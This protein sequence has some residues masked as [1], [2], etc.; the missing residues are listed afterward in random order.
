VRHI[1]KVITENISGLAKGDVKLTA[2]AIDHIEK[3]HRDQIRNAGFESITDF[4]R[5]SLNSIDAVYDAGG[6]KT[7]CLVSRSDKRWKTV[8]TELK[9]AD[10]GKIY[11]VKTAYPARDA[12][13]K[14]KKL[15]WERAQSNQTVAGSPSVTFI[16]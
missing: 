8:I 14:N 4:V 10:A 13:F 2:E 1:S 6:E 11:E 7:I 9:Q 15:L 16:K 5:Q 3:R 12:F